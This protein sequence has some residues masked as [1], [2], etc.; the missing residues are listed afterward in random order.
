MTTT[1]T[2]SFLFAWPLRSLFVYLFVSVCIC[3]IFMLFQL[4]GE[5][6]TA[7]ERVAFPHVDLLKVKTLGSV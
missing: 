6:V 2:I 4:A 3:F 7:G 1:I 5:Q